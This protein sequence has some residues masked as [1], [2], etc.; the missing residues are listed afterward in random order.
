MACGSGAKDSVRLLRKGMSAKYK[1]YSVSPDRQ[2]DKVRAMVHAAAVIDGF[3][4]S[5][6]AGA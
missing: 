6:P 2:N 4:P 1:Y 5:G 3:S